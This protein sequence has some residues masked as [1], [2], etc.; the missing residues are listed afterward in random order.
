MFESHG[1]G[2]KICNLGCG[3]G[4]TVVLLDFRLKMVLGFDS[5]VKVLCAFLRG[6]S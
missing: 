5:R 6:G 2:I 4:D 3:Y 1:E